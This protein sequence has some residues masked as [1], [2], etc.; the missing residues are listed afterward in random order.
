[1]MAAYTTSEGRLINVRE[2]R[3]GNQKKIK[4]NESSD[5]DTLITG[6]RTKKTTNKRKEK[7]RKQKAKKKKITSKTKPAHTEQKTE[8]MSI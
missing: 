5:T 6:H 7:K 1:M 3:W 4:E 2:I 8:E